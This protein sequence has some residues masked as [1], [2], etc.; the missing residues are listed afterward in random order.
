MAHSPYRDGV[1]SSRRAQVR[2]PQLP[3]TAVALYG[4]CLIRQVRERDGA[5]RRDA[6]FVTNGD[7]VTADVQRAGAH[8]E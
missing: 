5:Q 7:R 6:V 4:S 1:G 2:E 8:H 3:Y